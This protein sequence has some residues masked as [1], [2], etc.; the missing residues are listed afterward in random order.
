MRQIRATVFVSLDGV[1]QA[2][3][4]PEEDATGG[5]AH[6][7]WTVPYWD[8]VV[9]ESMSDAFEEPFELLLGRRTYDVFAAH[10]PR[11]PMDATAD[12]F[13]AGE[14]EVARTFNAVAKHVATRSPATLGWSNSHWLGADVPAAVRE[15]KRGE[16]PGLLVQGS[17][18]LLQT[19]LAHDLVD[20]LRLLVYPITLGTGKRL[21]GQGTKPAA[22]EVVGSTMSPSG[23][24]VTTYVRSG[25]V[26]TGSFAL[27]E[28]ATSDGE[29]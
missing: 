2:P 17:S 18:M 8:D 3:G 9:A 26:R 13:D 7:G 29:R 24:V 28:P 5:F 14:A 12:G 4:G 11:V 22:F 21:F 10:W 16:G 25:E 1:M 15:L 23:V 27:A 20:E 6:G 19:L